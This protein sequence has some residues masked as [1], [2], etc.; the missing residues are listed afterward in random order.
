MSAEEVL[1]LLARADEGGTALVLAA[2]DQDQPESGTY[3]DSG[4]REDQPE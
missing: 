4:Q 1:A 3:Q 2:V